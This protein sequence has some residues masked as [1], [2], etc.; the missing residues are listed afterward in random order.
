VDVPVATPGSSRRQQ[1]AA[2]A[3]A[4]LWLWLP[5]GGA[6]AAHGAQQFLDPTL[7]EAVDRIEVPEAGAKIVVTSYRPKGRGPFPWIVL[8]HGSSRSTE[9]NRK[10]GRNRNIPLVHQWVDRGYAVIVPVRRGYGDSGGDRLG[11]DY[12]DCTRP[13][14][15]RAGEGA[16][17]DILAAVEWAKSHPDLDA[18]RW[19][20]V[21]E[22][23][24]GFASI[25]T[26][27]TQPRGLLAVLAF[28]PGRGGEAGRHPGKP[29]AVPQ[30]AKVI[31]EIAPMIQVPVL[32]FYAGND[33]YFGP[34]AQEAWFGAFH[35][36]GGRGELYTIPAFP[37]RQGH[38][39]FSAPH[40]VPLWTPAVAGFIERE[41]LPLPFQASAG[42]LPERP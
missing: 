2:I 8:S 36:A 17:H 38:G 26:A 28:S 14:F 10:I 34:E 20:L 32:W 5:I 27:S 40:G 15:H 1:F 35:D 7:R 21:G 24:G 3:T 18:S 22:S 42:H 33:Q 41:H 12:G 9:V 13:D 25:Y 30:L 37:E 31:S 39:V 29:C 6:A 16:A 23:A 19:M 11:D 4:T